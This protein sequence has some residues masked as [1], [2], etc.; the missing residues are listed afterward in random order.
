MPKFS[1]LFFMAASFVFI[2]FL[3]CKHSS[4]EISNSTTLSSDDILL[5][6]AEKIAEEIQKATGK[7]VRV[8][9]F[10]IVVVGA[11]KNVVIEVLNEKKIQQATLKP[12]FLSTYPSE[13]TV[14]KINLKVGG[15]SEKDSMRS[16]LM[17]IINKNNKN[18]GLQKITMYL[19]KF[20]EGDVTSELGIL[21]SVEDNLIKIKALLAE[22]RV[23]GLNKKRVNLIIENPYGQTPN[24]VKDSVLNIDVKGSY[25]GMLD[26]LIRNP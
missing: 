19:S 3:S 20:Y 18:N 17:E 13:E 9:R 26:F 16:F 22:A 4:N 10:D 25:K 5:E 23:K 24:F 15:A 21:S 8:G 6:K 14:D 2:S 12:L 11:F 7:E 1:R